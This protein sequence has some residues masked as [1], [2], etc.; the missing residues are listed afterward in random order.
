MYFHIYASP[1]RW[2]CHYFDKVAERA[3]GVS[4]TL[5]LPC[6]DDGR[7]GQDGQLIE[8]LMIARF[9]AAQR[10]TNS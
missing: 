7:D 10:G 4:R 6:H 3:H 8:A 9:L 1:R 2:I 5:A